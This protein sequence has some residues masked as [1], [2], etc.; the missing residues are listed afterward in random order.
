MLF[1]L[2]SFTGCKNPCQQLCD[3]IADFVE[4]ECESELEESFSKEQIKECRLEYR[5]HSR[6]GKQACSTA[7][8]KLKEEW[9]CDDMA[10]YFDDG[11]DFLSSESN[12]IE[13][14]T[15]LQKSSEDTGLKN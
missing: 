7:L 8:P 10:V 9:T 1:L 15:L 3:E 5:W 4:N 11:D 13:T 2:F 6:E 14:D 12:D